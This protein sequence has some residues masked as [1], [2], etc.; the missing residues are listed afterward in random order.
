MEERNF[1]EIFVKELC[2]GLLVVFYHDIY[3]MLL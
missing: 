2:Y 1:S 3:G